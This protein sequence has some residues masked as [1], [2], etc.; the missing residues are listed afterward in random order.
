[1]LYDET[2]SKMEAR[3]AY[4]KALDINPK[5][6][7][8]HHNLGVLMKEDGDLKGAE[9]HL[10]TF[11]KL[12]D[13][14]GRQNGDA[15]YSLGILYLQESRDKDAKLL[16][17]KAIDTDP[18]VPH[19]NNAMGDTYLVEKRPDLSIV[20]YQKAIE[21]DPNYAL[22]YSGL[23]DAY[24]QLKER[25]KALTAYQKAL[26]LRPDY[27]LVYYKL[28]LFYEETNSVEAIKNFEKYLQSGKTV[29]YRDEVAAKIEA[30]K[31]SSNKP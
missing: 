18:S 21:K 22:S 16:L 28:G 20:Y 10:A 12:E 3:R 27:A 26:Q 29:A 4:E 31:L 24:A 1:V 13:E 30:L 23:G 8:A 6:G 19:F 9:Q 11:V 14:A 25:N 5:Y 7:R 17:Q 15:Y 2:G